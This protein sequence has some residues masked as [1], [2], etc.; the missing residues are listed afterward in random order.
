M[1]IFDSLPSW[2]KDGSAKT[3]E[4][5]ASPP[6]PA[7]VTG[8]NQRP[9]MQV[10]PS[11]GAPIDQVLTDKIISMV[12]ETVPSI[13]DLLAEADKITSTV[14]DLGMRLNIVMSLKGFTP[15]QASD[16]TIALK[17]A[18]DGVAQQSEGDI[19]RARADQVDAPNRRIAEL[20]QKK[21][22]LLADIQAID[23]EVG[24]TAERAAQAEARIQAEQAKLAA[25]VGQAKAWIDSL[26]QLI[27][28]S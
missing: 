13:K 23:T 22:T 3:Q 16:A 7:P 10:V 2:M 24:A 15:A 12:T 21:Q 14:P 4:G 28:K 27:T 19:S 5:N 8:M 11:Y 20:G 6:A 17:R 1:S 18:L 9:T 25:S 26:A